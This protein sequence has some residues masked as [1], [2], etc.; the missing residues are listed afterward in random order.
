MNDRLA[1]RLSSI[2]ER[3]LRLAPVRWAM[4]VLLLAERRIPPS[5][6]R[7]DSGPSRPRFAAVASS[8]QSPGTTPLLVLRLRD[9]V[10]RECGAGPVSLLRS[11][12]AS[13]AAERYRKEFRLLRRGVRT[14]PQVPRRG[15]TDAREG[16]L[17]VLKP[18]RP[19][20][21]R[22]AVLVRYNEA[23][24]RFAALYNVERLAADYRIVLEPSTWGYEDP[25]IVMFVGL[26]TDVVVQAQYAPDFEFVQGIGRN[27]TAVRLGAADWV[28]PD[29]FTP[30]DASER[31]FDV[32]MVASWMSLKRHVLLFRALS[33]I[34]PHVRRVALVGYPSAG[35]TAVDV[36]REAAAFGWITF[37]RSTNV[38]RRRRWQPCWRDHGSP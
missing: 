28:D 17:I 32:I 21:E 26:G 23:F 33:R 35:R 3:L 14:G 27:V 37:W 6:R 4:V 30:S 11:Y 2:A 16:D 29:L 34:K 20:G 1:F 38:C 36:K 9:S 13:D 12:A 18:H 31:V 10:L 8:E 15:D 22:G 25:A 19:H 5:A 7:R 24:E